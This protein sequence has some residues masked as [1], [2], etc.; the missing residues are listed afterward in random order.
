MGREMNSSSFLNDTIKNHILRE[1]FDASI[2][3][4]LVSKSVSN[5]NE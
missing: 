2:G 4:T 1:D 3:T 5:E